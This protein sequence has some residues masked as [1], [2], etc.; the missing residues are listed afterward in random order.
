MTFGKFDG[1]HRGHQTLVRKVRELGET[2]G[3]ST[4]VCAFDMKRE[5][6][7]MTREER[8]AHLEGEV[9]YLVDCPFSPEFRKMSAEDFIRVIICG[10]F[11][12]SQV[13]VGTDFHYGYGQAGDAQMLL[14][15]EQ[16][17][18]YEAIVLEKERYR[19]RVIS[20]TY[21]KELMRE[22]NIELARKLLGYAYGIEGVV[23]HGKQLGR[24][25]GFPTFN[26]VWPKEKIVPERGVYFSRILVDGRWYEGITNVGV[27]PTV[28]QEEKVLA[29]SFL[30]GYDGNAY[31]KTVRIELLS[32]W[33][34]EQRFG[35][36]EEMKARVKQDIVRGKAYF[37]E[38]PDKF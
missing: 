15:Y 16:K 34:P 11:R 10:V 2:K 9:D 35:S 20:S 3:V 27:K 31:G 8:G 12:A 38:N 21:I 18:G 26:V 24:T 37:A 23:E 14:E 19:D 6:L 13:V 33:R 4:A 25:L 1:L 30:F 29:E 28:S 17:Y 32:F 5:G 36:V 7:L 22:G